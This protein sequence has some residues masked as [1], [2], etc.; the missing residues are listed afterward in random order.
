MQ[1]RSGDGRLTLEGK[2]LMMEEMKASGA[3]ERTRRV[4][5]DMEGEILGAISALELQTGVHNSFLEL[6][7]ERLKL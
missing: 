3:L 6:L 7:V 4:L 5:L 2:L 1:R